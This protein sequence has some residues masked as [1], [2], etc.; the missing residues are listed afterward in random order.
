MNHDDDRPQAYR[1]PRGNLKLR[2]SRLAAS[3]PFGYRSSVITHEDSYEA[4]CIRENVRQLRYFGETF[5]SFLIFMFS[6][7]Q[8]NISLVSDNVILKMLY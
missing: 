4:T 6:F 1:Y 3:F 7:R 8:Q 5:C 2:F